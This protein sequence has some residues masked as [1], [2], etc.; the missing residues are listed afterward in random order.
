MLAFSLFSVPLLP[1]F[2]RPPIALVALLPLVV[3]CTEVRTYPIC[4]YDT[5]YGA[6]GQAKEDWPV[7]QTK[8]TKTVA[9]VTEDPKSIVVVTSRAAVVKTTKVEDE[10]LQGIWPPIACYGS[11]SGSESAL[12]LQNCE[13]YIRAYM[14]ALPPEKQLAEDVIVPSCQTISSAAPTKQPK[15]Q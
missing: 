15:T 7:L 13:K 9:L 8:L 6:M 11:S 5:T 2:R 4:L 12:A 1:C 14:K 10:A 3:S